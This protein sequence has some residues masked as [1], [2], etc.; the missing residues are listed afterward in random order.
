MGAN[1]EVRLEDGQAMLVVNAAAYTSLPGAAGNRTIRL[2]DGSIHML[3]GTGTGSGSL[4][5]RLEDGNVGRITPAIIP[6]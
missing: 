4:D 2:P 1:L 6:P 3:I 5:T